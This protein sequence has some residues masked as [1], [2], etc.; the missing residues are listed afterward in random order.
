M[1]LKRWLRRREIPWCTPV[2]ACLPMKSWSAPLGMPKAMLKV[3]HFTRLLDLPAPS[4]FGSFHF[5]WVWFAGSF[6]LLRGS[7]FSIKSNWEVEPVAF[8]YDYWYQPRRNIMVSTSW[9]AP[10]AIMSSFNPKHVEEGEQVLRWLSSWVVMLNPVSECTM[11]S[12]S[13]LPLNRAVWQRAELLQLDQPW[14]DKHCWPRTRWHHATWNS[15]SAWA[16][17]HWGLRWMCLKL[18]HL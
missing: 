2:T 12:S 4:P 15:L 7:D 14:A 9:G 3:G 16:Y 13:F 6:I 8:N 11:H 10:W 5:T 18:Y 1:S 17:S